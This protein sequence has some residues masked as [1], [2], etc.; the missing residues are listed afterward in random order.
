MENTLK[1][2]LDI[3]FNDNEYQCT[4]D[5]CFY[6]KKLNLKAKFPDKYFAIFSINK[7]P[8]LSEE[9]SINVYIDGSRKTFPMPND[10]IFNFLY[11]FKN[12]LNLYTNALSECNYHFSELMRIKDKDFLLQEIRD[13]KLNDLDIL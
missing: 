8:K 4:F 12:K 1:E 11:I 10:N 3:L 5:K 13:S 9:Y 6:I 2:A 7:D